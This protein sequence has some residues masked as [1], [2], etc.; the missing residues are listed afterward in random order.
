MV[1][2]KLKPAFKDYI[3]G[4]N[5]LVQSFGME[6]PY[7]K[8]A[9]AWVLSCHPDGENVIQN[10]TFAGRTLS[11]VLQNEGKAW[12]GTHGSA[13]SFFPVLIKLIDAPA[14]IMRCKTKTNTARP[15]R[16]TSSTVTMTPKSSMVSTVILPK[17]SFAP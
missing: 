17:S 7:D 13:F 3:W 8:T 5:M 2:L 15:K 6:S 11:D 9:E 10:G 4:G 14:M 1:P 12:L 16:G